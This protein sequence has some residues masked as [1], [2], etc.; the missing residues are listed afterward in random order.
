MYPP[1]P[2]PPSTST[3]HTNLLKTVVVAEQAAAEGK[4]PFGAVLVDEEGEVVMQQ[5]NV[6]GLNHAEMTLVGRA[7]AEYKP[8]ELWKMTLYTNF[9]P[10][11]MCTGAI[12]WAN[13]GHIIYGAPETSLLALTGSHPENPTMS[14]TCRETLSKGV[15]DV[16]VIGPVA[17]LEERILES[18][19]EFWK[20][21]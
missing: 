15:K 10:C 17:E 14:Q 1:R 21:R 3:I 2:P 8:E 12:Y 16:D 9:E 11:V 4:H 20:T 6:D 19:R 18:H 13:I 5:G 7:F